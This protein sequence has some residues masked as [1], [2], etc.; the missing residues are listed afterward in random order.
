M[1]AAEQQLA[2]QQ[3]EAQEAE[4]L[5]DVPTQQPQLQPAAAKEE[6]RLEEPMLAQ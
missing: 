6:G 3:Q 5:P 2:E 1:Q 4:A